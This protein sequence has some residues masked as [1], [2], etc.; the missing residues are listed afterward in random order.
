[1][2]TEVPYNK[3]IEKVDKLFEKKTIIL[4]YWAIKVREK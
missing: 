2:S 1:M 4:F 3:P